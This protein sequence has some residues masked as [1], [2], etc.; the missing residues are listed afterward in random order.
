MSTYLKRLIGPEKSN[1]KIVVVSEGY[2]SENDFKQDVFLLWK[3]LLG[4]YPFT[5]LKHE[6]NNLSLYTSFQ[7]SSNSGCPASLQSTGYNN[8]NTYFN[9][10]LVR[11]RLVLN[12]DMLDTFLEDCK[13]TIDGENVYL[14][15]LLFRDKIPFSNNGCL[16]L[17]LLPSLST[18]VAESE[19]YSVDHYYN[20][21][22]TMDGYVEQLIVRAI[23]KIIG[24]GDEYEVAGLTPTI[25][26]GESIHNTYPNLYYLDEV[27][28]AP[29]AT[30]NNFKW[31]SF[32][33]VKN[34]SLNIVP[35]TILNDIQTHQVSYDSLQ[36]I[37][38]GGGYQYK[39]YRSAMD[40]LFRRGIGMVELPPK[41]NKIG[42]CKICETVLIRALRFKR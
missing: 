40:C 27:L 4:Y 34:P 21:A 5:K 11:N 14:K 9:S 19:N 25:D 17:V 2:I 33:H 29:L 12:L 28:N 35:N 6:N 13:L 24:L 22:T 32:T 36:L 1:F 10:G 42:L 20:I 7:A 31:N 37:E 23:G 38:G 15:D 16:I 39:L 30:D 8:F 41:E 3:R 26:E 18:Y